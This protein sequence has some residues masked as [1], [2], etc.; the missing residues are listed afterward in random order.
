MSEIRNM[1]QRVLP[2]A[3][4]SER[5]TQEIVQRFE[6]KLLVDGQSCDIVNISDSGVAFI[7]REQLGND[8][9]Y[10]IQ[11]SIEDN[12]PFY[13]GKGEVKHSRLTDRGW[14]HG[15]AFTSSLLSPSLFEAFDTFI[16]IKGRLVAKGQEFH[17]VSPSFRQLTFEIKSFMQEAKSEL[18]QA[19]KRLLHQSSLI[20]EAYK[21]TLDLSFAPYFVETLKSFSLRLDTEFSAI[22]SKELRKLYSSFFQREVG[23]YYC[24][25][26][27]IGR[28]LEKPR[29]YAGDYEMMNQIYRNELDGETYFDRL[30]HKYGVNEFSSLSVRYRKEYLMMK[31]DEVA[32]SRDHITVGSVA[33]GPAREV[34]DYLLRVDVEKSHRYTFVLMD[35]DM[36]ALMNARRNIGDIIL[37]RGLKCEVYFVPVSVKNFLEQNEAAVAMKDVK[38]DLVYTAGLYD[39]LTQP[40]AQ[41]LTGELLK[42]VRE[43]GHLIVGNFHPSNPTK[44]ISE[45]VADWRLIHRTEA[46]MLALIGDGIV[47]SK[48]LHFDDQGIDVFLEVTR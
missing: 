47:K 19:E 38:F 28:A 18:D 48:A 4:R 40:V 35:Q 8:R 27:F 5:H 37:R 22:E 33:C 45:L 15:L 39:Y 24:R 11:M 1:L 23:E 46:D 17:R 36:E 2:I 16:S 30:V 6:M 13:E 3:V 34:V 25:S 7:A 20:K 41:A 29:G 31:I 42:I 10:T 21:A 14:L 32:S 43:E 12:S 9:P 44:T 26:V